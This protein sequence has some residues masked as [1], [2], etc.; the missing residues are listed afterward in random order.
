MGGWVDG[1]MGGWVD[2]WMGVLLVEDAGASPQVGQRV[3]VQ[4]DPAVGREF[5]SF[6]DGFRFVQCAAID[7]ND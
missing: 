1:W 2:G 6:D 3:V 7:L 4:M 5:P